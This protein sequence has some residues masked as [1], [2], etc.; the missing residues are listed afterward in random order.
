MPIAFRSP[1]AISPEVPVIRHASL[2]TAFA[3]ALAAILPVQSVTASVPAAFLPVQSGGTDD[4]PHPDRIDGDGARP[5][6]RTA[7][8]E[9]EIVR[10]RAEIV[11]LETELARLKAP[12]A[13]PSAPAAA[14]ADADPFASP[15]AIRRALERDYTKSLAERLPPTGD[16]AAGAIFRRELERWVAGANRSYRQAV[17][18]HGRLVRIQPQGD[19]AVVTLAPVDPVSGDSLGEEFTAVLEPRI[20]RRL[21]NAGRSSPVG[22]T[23]ALTGVFIP[24]IG[25][26]PAR[27]ERGIFDNPPLLGPGAE[28]RW[29]VEVESLVPV[30]REKP[31]PPAAPVP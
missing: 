2:G 9:A 1:T 12:P 20:A 19:R 23:W 17:R 7:E 31:A 30:R 15:Q 6:D 16:A 18:W 24:E 13:N 22:E 29:K 26:N 5:A 11:R 8:L 14:P 4:P 27:M 10:L 3:L 21:S 28:F 25:A